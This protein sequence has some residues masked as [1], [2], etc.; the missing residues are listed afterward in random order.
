MSLTIAEADFQAGRKQGLEEGRKQARE[1]ELSLWVAIGRIQLL[2]SLL[3]L[4]TSPIH[5]FD[6]QSLDELQ[7]IEGYLKSKLV[8]RSPS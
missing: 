1:K 8:N 3:N 5:K 4:P 6:S 7:T 2:E